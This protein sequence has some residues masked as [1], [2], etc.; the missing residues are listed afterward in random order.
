MS[1]TK[2]DEELEVTELTFADDPERANVV[3]RVRRFKAS[4]IELAEALAEVKRASRY[5]SWGYESFEAYA[6]K[7]LRLKPDTVDKLLGS[8]SFL[9][10]RAP[11]VLERDGVARS[12]PSYQA[13]DF[14][15]RAE[16]SEEAPKEAVAELRKRVIDE[17]AGLPQVQKQFKDVVFPPTADERKDRDKN[18]IINTATRLRD[19]LNDTRAVPRHVAVEVRTAISTMLDVLTVEQAAE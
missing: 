11:E 7:E 5:T 14:L 2:V 6:K 9:R 13:I 4:W 18:A 16:E 3:A 15:R 12:I 17:G 10:K 1:R 8:F 19:L